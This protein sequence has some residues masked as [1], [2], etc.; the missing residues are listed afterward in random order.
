MTHRSAKTFMVLVIL[1][2]LT[3]STHVCATVEW[4][5][6]NSVKTEAVP[7]DVAVS[8]D[9]KSVFVLTEDG[10]ILIYNRYGKLTDSINV[11]T[12]VDRIRIDPKGDRIFASSRKNKT[13]EIIAFD[14]IHK[15]NTE[16]SPVKG[17]QDAP[18][19]IA[20]FS[21]FQ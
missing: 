4:R 2:I 17:P 10:D 20:V 8:S 7:I 16:G 3:A 1:L 18:V 11:G 12:H 9:G 15:I 6:Q 14:F 5:I 21:D 13:I 19:I